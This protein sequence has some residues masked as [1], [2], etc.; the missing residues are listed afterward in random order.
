M[1]LNGAEE[2]PELTADEP[3]VT[4]SKPA[5]DPQ[6]SPLVT[7][8]KSR[9]TGLD[10]VRGFALLGILM[11]NIIDFAWPNQA[12][13]SV[14]RL[15][16]EPSSIGTIEEP[17]KLQEKTK[18]ASDEWKS[19]DAP[20]TD[21]KS[22]FPS[23]I[24]RVAAVESTWDVAEWAVANVFFANKMRTLFC[25]MFGAGMIYLTQRSI[26]SGKRPVWLYY[27]RMLILLLIGAL[28]GYLIWHGDILFLYAATGLYLY[29]FRRFSS[30]TLAWISLGM[31]V[32]FVSLIWTGAGFIHHIQVHGLQI[33][34]RVIAQANQTVEKLQLDPNETVSLNKAASEARKLA[35]NDLSTVDQLILRS[36]RALNQRDN[37]Q[38]PEELTR[39]IRL[40]GEGSYIKQVKDRASEAIWIHIVSLTP[41]SLLMFG[42]LMIL[43]MSLAK[44]G[45]FAGDWPR[46]TYRFLTFRLLPI[47]WLAEAIIMLVGRNQ[48]GQNYAN[49]IIFMPLHQAVIPMI[50]IG[51]ASA[52]ILAI[53]SGLFTNLTKRLADVG[54]MALSNYLSQSL[55]CTSIF[56]SYGLGLFG[57]MPRTSLALLV[58]AVWTLQLWW[59]PRWLKNHQFGPVEWLWRSLTYRKI[60]PFRRKPLSAMP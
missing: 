33:Q 58:F 57:T 54:R 43:G 36:Y 29:P 27:R 28:H 47:G 14:T 30:N 51:Y 20:K 25:I 22:A 15:Y 18:S 40:Y 2:S 26:D 55:I 39:V 52:I 3:S 5:D 7:E 23:A 59:S 38:K 4:F 46:Q 13:D 41:L 37:A 24:T 44:T 10:A 1:N 35:V 34:N 11:L 17:K 8:S 9:I 45:F 50:S 56:Y 53:E 6:F 32:G 21:L 42:W 19:L 49:M 48:S 16:Y 60:Q 31:F 12:Y